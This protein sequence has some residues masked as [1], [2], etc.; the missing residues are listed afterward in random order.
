MHVSTAS[1][2]TKELI[3]LQEGLVRHGV[4]HEGNRGQKKK[5]NRYFTVCHWSRRSGFFEDLLDGMHFEEKSVT[6]PSD[7]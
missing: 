7:F 1:Y 2:A 6:L 5:T 4:A 3:S